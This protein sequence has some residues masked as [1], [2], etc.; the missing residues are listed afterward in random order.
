MDIRKMLTREGEAQERKRDLSEAWVVSQK[1]ASNRNSR[2]KE[3][4][5]GELTIVE[6]CL[7]VS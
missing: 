6:C 7:I 3:I 4:L 1:T 5:G 2:E